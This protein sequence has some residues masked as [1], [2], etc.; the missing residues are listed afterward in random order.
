MNHF[1]WAKKYLI[2]LSLI[3]SLPIVFLPSLTAAAQGP[4]EQTVI[5]D[6]GVFNQRL[7]EVEAAANQL[8]AS[9]ADVR[10]RTIQTYGSA[11]NLDRYEAALEQQCPSWTDSSGN[12]KNNLLVL[13]IAVQERQTGIY[14][15]SQWESA[16]GSRWPQIQ[17]GTMNSRFTQGDFAGGFIAGLNEIN[18]L[19]RGQTVSPEASQG[20]GGLSAGWIVLIVMVVI[21]ALVAGLL[22]FRSSRKSRERRLAARQK[23]LLAKQGAASK[24]NQTVEAIQMLE[25]KVNSLAFKISGE[26]TAPL[27]EGFNRAKNLVDQ[28]AQKYSELGHSAGD[29]ENPKFG[30]AQLEVIA[31]EY[32]KVL[33]I[34]IQAGQEVSRVET[35]LATFQEAI[36]GFDDKAAGVNAAIEGAAGKMDSAQNAGFKTGFPAGILAR[37]RQSLVQANTLYQNKKYLPAGK[38][39]DEAAGLA[40]QASQYVD[41]L[42]QKKQETEAAVQALAARIE[43]VKELILQGRAIFDRISGLYAE[44]SWESIQGNGTE[45]ENRINWTL[46]ALEKAR[47]AASLDQQ[48]WEQASE[49]VKQGNTWLNEAGSFMH[50]ISAIETSLEAA[51]RDAPGEISAAQV[52]ITGA[53]KYIN[54]YDEDI[55]ESLEDDLHAAEKKLNSANEELHKDKAD[56][57]MVVK[58]AREANESADKILAQARSEHEAAERMRTRAAS[59]LRDARSRF[60]IARE[61]IQ[62]HPVDAGDEARRHLANADT[63]L[64][65]AEVSSDLNSQIALAETAENAANSAYSSARSRVD[66]AWRRRQQPFVPPVIIVPGGGYRGGGPSWGSRR[67]SPWSSGGGGGGR[68]GGGGSTGWGA[69]RGGGGG[70]GGG[71]RGGGGSTRW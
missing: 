16:L 15:G 62:D 47:S 13:M 29:P 69:G 8:V 53:W 11:G 35:A 7:G 54:A 10:V 59:A 48:N 40:T 17:S 25:I 56:Y 3:M 27:L 19:I 33:D 39:L 65:Q 57:L 12:R 71:G 43:T 42:P 26:D 20:Q 45:A 30:V 34:A 55:R 60:S 38:S 70:G 21:A 5:D 63:S 24:V 1:L 14:Y 4:C 18:S 32:Q 64:R 31:Q 61:Y 36:D 46:E 52:D 66:E 23:A 28:G 67:S 51:R 44:S 68:S 41:Q 22:L 9:G 50:S 58:L 37:A 49:A 2:I 6:A